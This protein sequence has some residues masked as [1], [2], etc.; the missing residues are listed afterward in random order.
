MPNSPA[1]TSYGIMDNFHLRNLQA[2]NVDPPSPMGT[3]YTG[4][5][6]AMGLTVIQPT[7]CL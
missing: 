7:T 2:A 3:G 5:R 6:F 4:K 1:M